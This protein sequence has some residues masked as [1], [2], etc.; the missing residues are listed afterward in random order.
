MRIAVILPDLLLFSRIEGAAAGSDVRVDRVDAP[1]DLPARTSF[2]LV[3]ADWSARE[4]GWEVALHERRAQG[5]RVI[6]FGP[7]TDVDAHRAA[8]AAGLGPM[9]ARSK[10]L[11]NLPTLF[12]DALRGVM[13]A[14]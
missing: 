4:P 14:R 2:D 12:G 9:W 10:L 1:S 11:S 8:A 7:H 3:L 6:L 13:P 5:S